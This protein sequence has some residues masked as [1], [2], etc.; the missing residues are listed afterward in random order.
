MATRA[1]GPTLGLWL[2]MAACAPPALAQD[3]M[4]GVNLNSPAFTQ[5]EMT[6]AD[7]AALLDADQ[8]ANL[9]GRRLNGLDLSG[10]DFS[11]VNLRGAY[12]NK[13]KLV[14]AKFDAAILDQVWA[15]DSDWTAASLKRASLFG[16]QM[17][18][19]TLMDA[20]LSGA[21]IAADLTRAD[22]GGAKLICPP[23]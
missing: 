17:R 21:R 7:I 23:T 14:G 3:M 13:A 10:F 16:T 9:A 20:D 15:L 6:R 2:I 1:S 18:G 22:L 19:A 5:A 12:L 11:G 4:S 8:P